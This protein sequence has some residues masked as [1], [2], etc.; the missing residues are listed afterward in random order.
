MVRRPNKMERAAKSITHLLMHERKKLDLERIRQIY[1]DVTEKSA[2]E[3]TELL[4]TGPW[5]NGAG[6]PEGRKFLEQL[7]D[8][9]LADVERYRNMTEEDLQKTP[10]VVDWEAEHAELKQ[11][12]LQDYLML[13]L[14]KLAGETD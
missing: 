8:E 1:V 11:A 2:K 14:E 4:A 6:A 7:R 10:L 9:D 3:L 5:E 13:G 12:A